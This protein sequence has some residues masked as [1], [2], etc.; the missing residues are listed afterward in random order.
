MDHLDKRFCLP[1]DEF[2]ELI[3]PMGGCLATDRILVDGA[4]V[5]YM[6][7][8]T[9]TESVSSG[10]T[11]MA[12]DEDQAYADDPDHWAIYEVNTICNF[13]PSITPHLESEIGSAFGRDIGAEGFQRELMPV[14]P[15]E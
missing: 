1:A 3:S 2:R 5:G 8:E 9:P 7:R 4:R 13:D 15:P 14:E 11:F 10:W 6:Y 12:G